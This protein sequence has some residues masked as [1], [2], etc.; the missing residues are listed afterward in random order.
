[1]ADP[2]TSL[3]LTAD[4]PWRGREPY[5]ESDRAFFHG[6]RRE[7]EELRHLLERDEL[8]LLTGPAG[9]GKTSLIRAGLL[10]SLS[11]DWLPVPLTLDWAA[12]SD[13]RPLNRQLL[14]AIE[15]AGKAREL[16]GP[17]SNPTDTL[18]EA[19]HR[20]GARWWNARQRVV[21]PV[22]VLDQFEDAFVAG[23]ANVGLR[24]HRD[25]FLEEL[26]QLINNRP[27]SRVASRIEDGTEREDAFDF[28]PAPVRILLV[29]REEALPK[30]AALR[31]L[32]PTLGRSELR[33]AAFTENQARDVLVRGAAQRNLFADGVVDQ[34]LPRISNGNERE[35]PFA[36]A[37][38][39]A[40]ARELAEH[41]IKRNDSQ[42][43]AAYFAP[44]QP[45]PVQSTA[46]EAPVAAAP[47][48]RRTPTLPILAL[49]VAAGGG[50]WLWQ[51]QQE[52]TRESSRGASQSITPS[53]PAMTRPAAPS[54]PA[55]TPEEQPRVV[56]ATP[57]PTPLPATPVPTPAP[58]P[59]PPPPAPSTPIPPPAQPEPVQEPTTAP[60]PIPAT[61]QPS[62]PPPA[63][64][65]P[66]R[67]PSV[68]ARPRE[69][70][71]PPKAPAPAAIVA[72]PP[73][74]A[75]PLR[76][77]GYVPGGGG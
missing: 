59:I 75:T 49:L 43:T 72:T 53:E 4:V 9:V 35:T 64:T 26:S 62:T 60:M 54:T 22:I 37:T 10:P 33:L 46:Q 5:A 52:S 74:R 67:K 18:W 76:K 29:A 73:P 13:Q 24:R 39:S 42:I 19:F 16:E 61:P 28:G 44:A 8:T 66:A 48:T 7:I 30:I 45:A 2:E 56:M 23:D 40:Q 47:P 41:R 21:T 20:T 32:L 14:E 50:A 15:A 63:T 57:A 65:V 69:Q 3:P 6:R 55:A 77:P 27:P 17:Q 38:L 12:A 70:A 31:G 34:L 68:A 25:R 1:M 36:P 58:T 71:E 51:Q 11:P